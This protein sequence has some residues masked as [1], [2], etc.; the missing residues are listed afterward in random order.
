MALVLGREPQLGFV[1]PTRRHVS[2]RVSANTQVVAGEVPAPLTSPRHDAAH[3]AEAV[4][5]AGS[6]HEAVPKEADS[7]EWG[8]YSPFCAVA[9]RLGPFDP[10]H[11]RPNAAL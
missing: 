9:P 6:I 11:R 2:A 10:V 4:V 1:H 3:P 8:S 5:V 7:H